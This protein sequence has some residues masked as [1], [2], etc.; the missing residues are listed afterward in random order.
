MEK[1][2]GCSGVQ[3]LVDSRPRW[4]T[5]GVPATSERIT[6]MRKPRKQ[7][8]D[9]VSSLASDVLAGRKKPTNKEILTLAASTLGQD[10]KKGP[11]SPKRP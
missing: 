10:E 11:R 3:H 5:H 1:I 6:I 4:P 8:T 9:R 7:T 2:R